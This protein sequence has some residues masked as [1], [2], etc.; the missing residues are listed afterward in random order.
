PQLPNWLS[1]LLT[2][3]LPQVSTA[4][5]PRTGQRIVP[6]APL[7]SP[8]TTASNSRLN[9]L[10]NDVGLVEMPKSAQWPTSD[11]PERSANINPRAS[12]AFAQNFSP[13]SNQEPTWN[14]QLQ[15]LKTGQPNAQVGRA[16]LQHPLS[17]G[18]PQQPMGIS[19]M[20]SVRP[21]VDS[22]LVLANAAD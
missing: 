19:P 14:A 9:S 13:R 6:Y 21:A 3:P 10:R 4:I 11:M 1:T 15:L 22:N 5:D 2:M 18:T 8:V 7:I 17:A 12:V 20:A 16:Q